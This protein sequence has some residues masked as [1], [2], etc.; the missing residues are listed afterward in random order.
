MDGAIFPRALLPG[1]ALCLVSTRDHVLSTVAARHCAALCRFGQTFYLSDRPWNLP[2]FT[3]HRVAPFQSVRDYDRTVLTGLLDHL[4]TP[5]VLVAQADGFVCDPACWDEAFLNYDYI[6]APWP[7]FA[8][9]A[10]GNGG[11]SL[12][13]RRLLTALR[14]MGAEAGEMAEDVAIARLWRP[15]LEAEYGI[16]FAPVALARRFSQEADLDGRAS[17]GVHGI[18]H[19]HRLYPGADVAFLLRHLA[20]EHLDGWRII[21]LAAQYLQAGA[22]EAAAL[23]LAAARRHQA[24]AAI[25]AT[26]LRL[27]VPEE[28]AADLLALAASRQAA[29]A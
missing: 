22:A 21:V 29:L 20:P 11:F 16:R 7:Q 2:D 3:F 9:H 23:V 18:Y 24:L 14:D 27:G 4:E 5:F 12:R 10:V 6:G 28:M 13:S 25:D 17:F 19:L 26:L 15:V 1:V 8:T